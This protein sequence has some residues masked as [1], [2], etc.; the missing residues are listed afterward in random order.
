MIKYLL[1]IILTFTAGPT[2][3]QSKNISKLDEIPAKYFI[4]QDLEI[5]LTDDNIS[6]NRGNEIIFS[7]PLDG[8]KI[9]QSSPAENYFLITN[10]KFSDDKSDYPIEAFAFNINGEVISSQN[11]TAHYDLPHPLFA[12]NDAGTFAYLDLLRLQISIVQGSNGNTISLEKD[13]PFEME[14]ACYI[15]ISETDVYVFGSI[16]PT[17]S[18]YPTAV[19]LYQIEISSSAVTKVAVDY[20]A[21]LLLKIIEDKIFIS[22][23]KLGD[24]IQEQSVKML[25]NN[26]KVLAEANNTAAESLLKSGDKYYIKFNNNFSRLNKDLK[27][28][29]TY[30]F[31]NSARIKEMIWFDGGC[32]LSV[33]EK[34]ANILYKF[35][36]E[37][38]IDFSKSLDIFGYNLID[39]LKSS[40]GKIMILMKD[41]TLIYY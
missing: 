11:I 12:I 25:D 8:K 6:I 9:L 39:G 29:E 19:N 1:L 37:F 14:R 7:R 35:N 30:S 13:A 23:I 40:A 15:E 16:A 21:P 36:E 3:S 18:G 27:I 5:K 22:G 33:E 28:E 41:N 17:G 10:Y 34:G 4:I 31:E 24:E 26:L 2:F 38:N 20:T 32:L